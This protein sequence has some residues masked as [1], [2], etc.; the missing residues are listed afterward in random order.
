[1]SGSLYTL[2]P[3]LQPFARELIR[4]ASAAGLSPRI[5]S[6]RR[7]TAEQARLYQRFLAGLSQYPVAPPGTSAHEYGFAF[8]LLIY[9]AGRLPELGRVWV[10]AGGVWGGAFNDP[11]HF[12]YPGF[13]KH[14]PAPQFWNT[15]ERVANWASFLI[16]QLGVGT[17]TQEERQTRQQRLAAAL[18]IPPGIRQR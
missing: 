18:G 6:T 12:E 2:I 1:M 9:D 4:V 7:S 13:V 17:E 16:P 15:F 5:T 3:E 11:I 14:A 10:N 8:D